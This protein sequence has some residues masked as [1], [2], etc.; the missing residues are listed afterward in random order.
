MYNLLGQAELI[1]DIGLVLT[2]RNG[3]SLFRARRGYPGIYVHLVVSVDLGLLF[4]NENVDQDSYY[5][6]NYLRHS[7]SYL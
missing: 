6:L 5:V 7:Y 4:A 3:C 2:R 1:P